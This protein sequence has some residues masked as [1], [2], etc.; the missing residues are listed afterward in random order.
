MPACLPPWIPASIRHAPIDF[1]WRGAQR[2]CGPV[3]AVTPL[4]RKLDNTTLCGQLS[5]CAGLLS[6]AAV[7]FMD[8]AAEAASCLE[9]AEAAFAYQVDWRYADPSAGSVRTAPDAPPAPSALMEVAVYLWKG[10]DR[11]AYG[12]SLY[13]PVRETF[14]AAHVVQHVMP[15]AERPAFVDWF[16]QVIARVQQQARAPE[17]PARYRNDFDNPEDWQRFI[18]AHRGPALPPE[19]LDPGFDY[20]PAQ[21]EALVARFLA[22]LDGSANRY[23]RTPQ[24]MLRLG[25]DGEPYRL[26]VSRQPTP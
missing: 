26:G 10:M 9:L 7:R 14:H 12:E 2:H 15:Q 23:L 16:E 6:W 5:L 1:A 18:A 4:L 11:A 19:L 17:G 8:A 24:E 20:Q 21:R 25:F 13:A 3:N 22:R